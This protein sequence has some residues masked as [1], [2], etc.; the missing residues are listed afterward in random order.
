MPLSSPR[1]AAPAELLLVVALTC[2]LA[3]GVAVATSA[4]VDALTE[5]D[6]GR[7]DG[8]AYSNEFVL[9]IE[10]DDDAGDVLRQLNASWQGQARLL[11]ELRLEGFG[12]LLHVRH[13]G[14]GRRQRRSAGDALDAA[15]SVEQVRRVVQQPVLTRER[16]IARPLHDSVHRRLPDE[17][18][19]GR[20]AAD[21][22]VAPGSAAGA[23]AAVGTLA[24][25]GGRQ[26]AI[27]YD[28]QLELPE[29]RYYE[30][31][32]VFLR[33]QPDGGIAGASS[34]EP[35]PVADGTSLPF[36]DPFLIDQWYL[37]NR[38]QAG[39]PR[40]HDL[41]VLPVWNKGITGR[42]VV[43][44]ILDDGVQHSHED[45][46]RN[47]DARASADLN[48]DFDDDP[49]PDENNLRENSH[50]T[51]C[52]G[53][54]AAEANNGICGV[55]VAFNARIGG[56]RMLDGVV[57][58][59]T[60]ARALLYNNQYISVY[61]ASWGPKDDGETMEGPG[62]YCKAALREGVTKGRGGLG[63]IFVWATGNG[64][65]RG[66]D[67]NADG[68]VSSP[69][70]LSVGSINNYGQSTYFMESCPSTMAVVFTG[71]SH[72]RDSPVAA[73][74]DERP[75]LKVVTTDIG[76][77]CTLNFQGTSS[78]APLAAGC[79]ALVLEANPL[80]TWRD[81]QHIVV[82]TAKIPNPDEPGWTINGAGY[83]VNDLFGF[84]VM[85]CG[86][87]VELAQHW[88][89]VGPQHICVE[90]GPTLIPPAAITRGQ[91]TRL[92]YSTD[93]CQKQAG[94]R[95]DELEHVEMAVRIVHPARGRLKLLLTSPAGTSSEMLSFR[96]NDHSTAGIDFTFSTVHSWGEDARGA[97]LLDV[98]D[99]SLPPSNGSS[100]SS[101]D[102]VVGYVVSW[103][104]TFYG[105]SRLSTSV[106]SS[107]RDKD[108]KAFEPGN[109]R[110]QKIMDAEQQS[111]EAVH[112]RAGKEEVDSSQAAAALH[113]VGIGKSPQVALDSDIQERLR[114]LLDH[115][116]HDFVDRLLSELRQGLAAHGRQTEGA[117]RTEAVRSDEDSEVD[118]VPDLESSRLGIIMRR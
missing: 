48:D 109:R 8:E 56:V 44:S 20:A 40:G 108:T 46:H 7:H 104:L 93:A 21:R 19:V 80:L 16:R 15:S 22:R 76:N 6:S 71:G 86:K 39:G 37:I 49:S 9:E 26:R 41:N 113:K 14:A 4:P 66:D 2:A 10:A 31:K 33:Y 70:T 112:I 72:E 42:G 5:L 34:G 24:A 63:S 83:H 47:Y 77:R 97:W 94:Y 38:G 64:G 90:K 100:P 91:T 32:N 67:C 88:Q 17:A 28:K 107:S 99:S 114:H 25:A 62:V 23:A 52:A 11:S 74:E 92:R 103:S 84:G 13:V 102:A 110:L 75:V 59:A 82:R 58:D 87:M 50:G 29:I 51:R 111:S 106:S 36:N 81:V 69:Y 118:T 53:E 35:S 115:A 105:T 27:V 45:L 57:T 18:A 95:I 98:V 12:Q 85:D 61:S 30:D 43:V 60:E 55:G 73:G 116:D 1:G 78:A 3:A 89:G 68:Y 54:V 79:V 96:P 101:H 117:V 65:Y